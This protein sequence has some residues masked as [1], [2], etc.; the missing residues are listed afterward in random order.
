MQPTA[1]TGVK[2]DVTVNAKTA[3]AAVTPSGSPVE[4]KVSMKDANVSAY[5]DNENEMLLIRADSEDYLKKITH[6]NFLNVDI[7]GSSL[8]NTEEYEGSEIA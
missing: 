5:Y 3:Y 2:F 7:P 6:L 4:I 8:G 1:E